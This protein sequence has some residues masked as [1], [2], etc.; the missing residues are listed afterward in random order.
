MSRQVCYAPA[1][2]CLVSR[3]SREPSL[4]AINCHDTKSLLSPVFA[5]LSIL[6]HCVLPLVHL[7]W[8]PVSELV[9]SRRPPNIA[10][11]LSGSTFERTLSRE[12]SLFAICGNVVRFDIG[13]TPRGSE[14]QARQGKCAYLLL[15]ER[16]IIIARLYN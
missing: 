13:R 5:G 2:P 4:F 9:S 8:V 16:R 14:A 12:P 15:L 10:L 11:L 6:I 1:R 3:W 7:S